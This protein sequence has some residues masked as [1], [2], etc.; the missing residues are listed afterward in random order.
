MRLISRLFEWPSSAAVPRWLAVA[1]IALM[2]GVLYFG[3][4]H[5]EDCLE[6]GID[7]ALFADYMQHQSLYRAH[8][9]QT[10]VDPLR[11]GFD[12]YYPLVR[13]YLFPG[14]VTL[15]FMEMGPGRALTYFLYTPL[16]IFAF[17]VL[18]RV[19]SIE[20]PVAVLAGF[21][22]S[23]LGLPGI[24]H[25]YG[26]LQGNLHLN[27][28]WSQNISLSLLIVASFWA[29]NGQWN[30][31]KAA[32]LF[33]PL[34]C[35][36][37]AAMSTGPQVFFMVPAMAA[38]GAASLLDAKRLADNW[39][40]VLAA[41]MVLAGL[42]ALGVL[43][44]F[45]GFVQYSPFYFF[46]DEVKSH[47]VVW[48]LVSAFFWIEPFG[49]W[50]I[51]LGIAGA[52]WTVIAGS[53]RRRLLAGTHLAVSLVYFPVA[54]W[55]VFLAK[56]YKGSSPSY[57]EMFILPYSLLFAAVLIWAVCRLVFSAVA[58]SL[59]R[60]A[61]WLPRQTA[62]LA[63]VVVVAVVGSYNLAEAV[64]FPDKQCPARGF[65]PVTPTAITEILQRETAFRPGQPLRG[66]VATVAGVDGR[67]AISWADLHAHD[68]YLWRT[69][70]ND[71]RSVGLWRFGI[72]TLFSLF[73]FAPPP[74]YLLV[75]EFLAR[76][77]DVQ[78][79][80][81]LT[82][83]R[84]DEKIMALWGVRYLITDQATPPGRLLTSLEV[85]HKEP[86][87]KQETLHL[88][89]LANPN[90]GNYSPTAVLRRPDFRS[91]LATM[92]QP[93]FNG[94]TTVVT[95]AALDSEHVSAANVRMTYQTYG[96]DLQA[97]S[98]GRSIL[99]LPIVYSHCW[100]ISAPSATLFRA[101][102]MQLGVAFSGKLDAKLVFRHGPI[103]AAD[104][105]LDDVADMKRLN[106]RDARA[107][108]RP[109]SKN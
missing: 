25:K 92:H 57:F 38:Y 9:T 21:L 52:L 71:H 33:A 93:D 12:G 34:L 49:R 65:N 96:F 11:A 41:V 70:G 14:A 1:A 20:W 102:L 56:D 17:V 69:V 55:I 48:H 105:R 80:A 74:Y 39:Q 7:G 54:Y 3:F 67:P 104:C 37:V 107:Q 42:A 94:R 83:T 10:G 88:T 61:A 84:I 95:D 27:P 45:Y 6:I 75:T 28:N 68:Y 22:F 90:L 81:E 16:L 64:R 24:V 2:F 63:L 36:V 4:V 53:G 106:I 29:L 103:L 50:A 99:V 78:T 35:V 31:R 19:M 76:P 40:R 47:P 100:S 58:P 60:K 46:P 86:A 18:G 72:P 101:N 26:Q 109:A 77:G 44:Y 43:T 59:R 85:T 89:E 91:G 73:G 8:F 79:R 98:A 13:E 108:P 87:P 62:F 97:D 51:V 66:I 15:P 30:W 5:N 23:S 32:L 82:L